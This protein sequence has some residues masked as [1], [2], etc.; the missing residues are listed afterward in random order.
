M[1]NFNTQARPEQE[2]SHVT[3]RFQDKKS[4]NHGMH[5]VKLIT[6]LRSLEFFYDAVESFL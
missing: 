2:R 1:I 3:K 4:L 5:A 6:I